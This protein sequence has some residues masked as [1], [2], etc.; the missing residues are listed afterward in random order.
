MIKINC[1]IG[2]REPDNK[3]DVALMQ[4]IHIANIACGG[5]AGDAETVSVFRALANENQVEVAAH[6]SYPDR[7]N[8]GR[9]R[10]DITPADL[11]RSLDE[12]YQMMPDVK[13]VKF[14]GA[15]YNECS[16]DETLAEQ[17]TTWLVANG[18]ERIITPEKSELAKAA[19]SKGIRVVPEAF[20]ERT[21][22]FSPESNRLSLTN[23]Q[24][25]YACI[26]ECDEAVRHSENIL[27][28][29]FV[30][31]YIETEEGDTHI[32]KVD[33]SAETICIHSDSDI[34]LDLARKLAA[35]NV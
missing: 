17:L 14:H 7:E 35:L 16:A 33:I 15:L 10:V 13:M 18:I 19:G 21:Y 3:V 12:Q 29:G 20:A 24:Q 11:S 4:Y 9:V 28:K 26:H 30:E 32:E 34:A 1:D 5:H 6:L 8:F 23:R 27:N 31:A 22:A 25:P 2:E